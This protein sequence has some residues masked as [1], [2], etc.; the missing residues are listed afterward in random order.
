VKCRGNDL[1]GAGGAAQRQWKRALDAQLDGED[2]PV[3]EADKSAR[4]LRAS[5]DP[6]TPEPSQ[7]AGQVV[8]AERRDRET[9]VLEQGPQALG[10]VAITL[11]HYA[12]ARGAEV[13][14]EPVIYAGDTVIDDR[15]QVSFVNDFDFAGVKRFYTV[16]NHRAG[17]VRAWHAHRHEAK[18]V[19][20]V[21]GAALVGAVFVGDLQ[22]PPRDL[23]TYRFVISAAQPRVLYIPAGYANGFMSLTSDAQLVFFSTSTLEESL[24]DDT[25]FEARY[26]DIWNV[27]ER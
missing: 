4:L 23:K 3:E 17:F 9:G 7:E 15:G 10:G 14:T 13:T 22:E 27:E 12:A 24:G 16:R 18:Y 11:R 21:E 25:R 20:V 2:D 26:W 6:E 8:L 19:T 1:R 5:E